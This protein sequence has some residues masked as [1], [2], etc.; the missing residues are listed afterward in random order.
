M[1]SKS[2]HIQH[3]I[4]EIREMWD[5]W[6]LRDE[7]R[8][9]SLDFDAFY[10]GFMAPYFGCYRCDPTKKALK[11]IDM[12]S[13][14]KVDWNEFAVYLKW[15]GRQYPQTKD[16]EELLSIAFRK[17]LI[18]AMQDETLKQTDDLPEIGDEFSD[19]DERDYQYSPWK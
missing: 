7:D 6:D 13:D 10:N 18:P 8:D 15:A 3:L 4:A 2:V 16:A 9:D 14:G 1:K 19:D 17:G 5:E 12:D 11:A